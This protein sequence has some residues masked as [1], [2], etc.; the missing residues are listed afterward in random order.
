MTCRPVDRP[1]QIRPTAGDLDVG[2]VDE[3]PLP[4]AVPGWS[5][6]VDEL[7]GEALHPPIPAH[8]IHRRTALG[9]QL[10]DIAVR[11]AVTQIP[12]TATAITSGENRNP[13]NAY[14]ETEEVTRS[15]SQIRPLAQPNRA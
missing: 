2:L 9:E 13:A 10:L 3:P 11:Q 14:D 12:G 1:V 4:W 5:G 15:V 8:V 6:S 7:G